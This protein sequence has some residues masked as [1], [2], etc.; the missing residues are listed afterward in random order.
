MAT[1]HLEKRIAVRL[2]GRL[3][4]VFMVPCSASPARGKAPAMAAISGKRKNESTPI[5]ASGVKMPLL[6]IC[7]KNG[8]PSPGAGFEFD[9]SSATTIST[10]TASRPA[11]PT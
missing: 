5:A 10:G 3:I 8:G 11:Q 6:V 2:T 9:R 4:Q 1:P 7:A